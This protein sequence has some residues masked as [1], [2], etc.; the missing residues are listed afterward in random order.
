[1]ETKERRRLDKQ[2]ARLWRQAEKAP[3]GSVRQHEVVQKIKRINNARK[4]A[5]P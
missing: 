3:L 1:M 2:N 5:Q 4:G